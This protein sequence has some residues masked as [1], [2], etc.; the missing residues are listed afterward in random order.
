MN[1]SEALRELYI[2]R[3]FVKL[4]EWGGC[5]YVNAKDGLIHELVKGDGDSIV[6][7]AR[8]GMFADRTDFTSSRAI[9]S[10]KIIRHKNP[11]GKTTW[12]RAIY[13]DEQGRVH[14]SNTYHGNMATARR[15]AQSWLYA[16][17]QVWCK[18]ATIEQR[19]ISSDGVSTIIEQGTEEI[20]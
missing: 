6:S 12:Y 13:Y 14:K 10:F 8:L 17:I 19:V 5:W 4:P 2:E 15:N 16:N 7:S 11:K 18:I 9:S 20:I 3:A 1:Y